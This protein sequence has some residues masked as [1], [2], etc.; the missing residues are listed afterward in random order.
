VPQIKDVI[1]YKGCDYLVYHVGEL[2]DKFWAIAMGDVIDDTV[3]LFC[4]HEGKEG[5]WTFKD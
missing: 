1:T 5:G 4:D 2:G 3:N